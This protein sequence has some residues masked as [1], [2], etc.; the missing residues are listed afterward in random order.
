MTGQALRIAIVDDE[1]PARNRLRDLLQDCA[2]RLELEVVGEAAN[3]AAALALLQSVAADVVLLDIR[4]PGMDGL[5]LAQHL[6]KLDEPPAVIFTTAYDAYAIKAFEV[7]AVDY[8]LKPIRLGRL[9]DALNRARAITPLRLDV[10]REIGPRSRSHLSVQERGRV[11]LVPVG[12]VVYL[13][14]ELKYVTIRTR[15]REFLLEESLTRLEQEFGER[16]VRVHRNCLVAKDYVSGFEKI[17]EEGGESR[18][19]VLLKGLDEKLPVSR[20]QQHVVKELGRF[21]LI[22]MKGGERR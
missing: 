21:E 8:L 18:W 1:A 3:G 15:E 17:G 13:R 9:F 11:Q 4:M 22:R 20:R 19:V 7:H 5:E 12:E 6:R 16:F 10:L 14:A 2:A